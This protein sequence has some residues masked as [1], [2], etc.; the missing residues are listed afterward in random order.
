MANLLLCQW[1]MKNVFVVF[2]LLIVVSFSTHAQSES[3]E[4]EELTYKEGKYYSGD[5]LFT[6]ELLQRNYSENRS[7]FKCSIVE[8]VIQDLKVA[9]GY[10]GEFIISNEMSFLEIMNMPM[11]RCDECGDLVWSYN[12]SFFGNVYSG[13]SL[14]YYRFLRNQNNYSVNEIRILNI[15]AEVLY[16]SSF[17]GSD[18]VEMDLEELTI[19]KEAPL[20]ITAWDTKANFNLDGD[21]RIKLKFLNEQEVRA[22]LDDWPV[23]IDP[24][25]LSTPN[26][27]YQLANFLSSHS[28]NG[29]FL[30]CIRDALNEY[31]DSKELK[32]LLLQNLDYY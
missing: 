8:G 24:S 22:E 31:P 10:G 29:E 26:A 12:E 6:G 13:G 2:S 18:F 30:A 11:G 19:D 15:F 21:R 27:Y 4:F 17:D 28:M 23:K 9:K 16:S 5:S 7:G 14:F 32:V 1:L 3:A 20:L 25:N